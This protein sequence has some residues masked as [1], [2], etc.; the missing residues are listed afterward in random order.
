MAIGAAHRILLVIAPW[1]PASAWIGALAVVLALCGCR[2]VPNL[3]PV[4]LAQPGWETRQGQAVWKANTNA[5]E[6]AGELL[7]AT[8][9]QQGMVLQFIKTPFPLVIAQ[10]GRAGWKISFSGDREFA[11]AGDPPGRISWF[12]L[13]AAIASRKLPRGW[14]F[15]KTDERSWRLENARTGEF[16]EGFLA[17]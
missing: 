2:T 11:E 17:L 14:K 15:Q 7:L 12:Q 1:L 5:P 13:P 4:D 8:H 16:I 9:P 6:I 3:P 10:A